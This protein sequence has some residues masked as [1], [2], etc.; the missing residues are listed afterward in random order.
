MLHI[1]PYPVDLLWE[2]STD[3]LSC[4]PSLEVVMN[5][6]AWE[7]FWKV[8][9]RSSELPTRSVGP[10]DRSVVLPV[11]RTNLSR[12]AVSLVGGNPRVP[13]SHN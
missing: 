4:T 11:G 9:R 3:V 13:M 8:F 2:K 12:T 7:I 1:L 5:Q 10:T 6:V